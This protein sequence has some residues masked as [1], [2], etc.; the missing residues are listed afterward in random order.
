M[1]VI[2]GGT[3]T[4]GQRLVPRLVER[5]LPVRVFTRDASR[6]RGLAQGG[7]EV[8]VGDVRDRERV[9]EAVQNAAAVISA[10][11]GFIGTGG[12]TPESV[13]RDGNAHLISAAARTGAAFMLISAIGTAPDHPW[14][15]MRAKHAAEE[16]LRQSGVPYAIIRPSAFTETWGG[17]MLSSLQTSG[18]IQ[19]FGRGNN[20]S[21]YVSVID[22]AALVERVVTGER[23]GSRE[24]VI[25][26]PD[27]LTFNQLAAIVQDVAGRRAPVRHIPRPVLRAMSH[28]GP[29]NPQ[30]ARQSR[31]AVVLDT[32]DMSF[33]P[34]PARRQFPDVPE[35]SVR[36]A[37]KKL[38]DRQ[39]PAKP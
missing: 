8:F 15:L 7:F 14:E 27:T 36:E 30:L 13:D 28:A 2:A 34:G 3:G 39:A 10:V 16:N 18:R 4:L 17:M 35:T 33:D 9:A 19:V 29:L 12:V 5:G 20:P 25:G 6:A 22:V 23:P 32:I 24:I 21:N 1:I 26:G 11:H 31:G 38:L 37:L